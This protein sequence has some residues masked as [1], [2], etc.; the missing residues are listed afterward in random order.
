MR[1]VAGL[2]MAAQAGLAGYPRPVA[3]Q[4]PDQDAVR[5]VIE[6]VAGSAS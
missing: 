4:T 6:A 1:H 3:A 2:A 5:R